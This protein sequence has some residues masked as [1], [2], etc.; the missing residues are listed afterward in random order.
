MF[1]Y[2]VDTVHNLKV[3]FQVPGF[4]TSR[5]IVV[6]AAHHLAESSRQSDREGRVRTKENLNLFPDNISGIGL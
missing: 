5:A 1:V 4:V 3:S 6:Y 2:D